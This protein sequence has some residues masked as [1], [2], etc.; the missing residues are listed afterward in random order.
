MDKPDKT[1]PEHCNAELYTT[2]I[3]IALSFSELHDTTI[4]ALERQCAELH[5]SMPEVI[6][7]WLNEMAELHS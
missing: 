6:A 5:V 1:Q 7:A 4:K 2:Y 3:T